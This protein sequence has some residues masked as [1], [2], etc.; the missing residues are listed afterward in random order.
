MPK[1]TALAMLFLLACAAHGWWR[2]Q[3]FRRYEAAVERCLRS[4][5]DY[6]PEFRHLCRVRPEP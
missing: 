6:P 3:E 1:I 5:A 2:F 4:Y